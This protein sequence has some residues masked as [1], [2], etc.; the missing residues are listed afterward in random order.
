MA[1]VSGEDLEFDIERVKLEAQFH[2]AM[3]Q[4]TAFIAK[5]KIEEVPTAVKPLAD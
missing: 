1:C 4:L 2:E 5:N 3:A